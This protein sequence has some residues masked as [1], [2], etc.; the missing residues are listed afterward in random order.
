MGNLPTT[1]HGQI[2]LRTTNPFYIAGENVTGE[3]YLNL[4]QPFQ[5]NTIYLKVKGE[6]NCRWEEQETHWRTNPDG[7]RTSYTETVYHKGENNFYRHKFPVFC[8]NY[9]T[10]PPGQ[11]CFPFSLALQSNLP[12]TFYE[13][14]PHFTAGIKYKIKVEL[15]FSHNNETALKYSQPLIIRE[16]IK[17][18][19]MFNVPVENSINAKTWCC[20]AQGLSKIKCFFEKN[21][22]CPDELA[23]MICEIDNSQCNLS[24]RNV[25]I[26]LIMNIH[27][28]TNHGRE[29]HFSETV[30]S[31]D[32]P[33]IGA[34]QTALNDQRKIA[35]MYL[36]NKVRSRPIQPSTSGNFVRCEYVLA[37]KTVLDGVTCCTAD[38][39]V[40]IPLTI[41]AAPLANFNQVVAPQNWSPQVMPVYN[42]VF[43]EQYAYVSAK[44]NN[45]MGNGMGNN[46]GYPQGAPPQNYQMVGM[47]GPNVVMPGPGQNM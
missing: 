47:V 36:T 43:S 16:P 13:T 20:L 5:G 45:N 14:E 33:G 4:T 11:Y 31:F 23:N 17:N 8:F 3:I 41:F 32:L 35:G 22:Y 29:R 9:P 26:Q 18:Q 39:E 44:A 21:T 2:F 15:C 30:N 1:P 37:V 24:V 34:R 46:G 19:M 10:I 27:L 28:K 7:T 38:P 6:E 12:G 40:R 25:N 42:C